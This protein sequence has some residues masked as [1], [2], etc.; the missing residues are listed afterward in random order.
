MKI[1]QALTWTADRFPERTGFAGERRMTYREWDE[2]T[3]KIANAML[4]LGVQ[5]GDRVATFTANTEVM[6]STHLA[7][8]KIGAMSTPLNI[9]LSVPELTYCINDAEPRLV[10]T[11]DHAREVAEKT[12]S[13]TSAGLVLHSG[14]A[15]VEG[16][17]DFDT[18]VSDAD[19]DAPGLPITDDD[20]SVMLYTSGTTGKPKGVPR[21]QRNEFAASTAHVM[22]C[23]YGSGES[24]LGAMPMYHTMGLR[25]L[26]SMVLV[27]GKFVEMP[28]FQP[29]KSIDLIE[30]EE[31]SALYLVPTA[32]WAMA[33]TGDLA[34]VAKSV[35]KL[36][37]AGAAMTSSL[38]EQL[39]ELIQPE[40]FVNHYGSSEVYTF[41]IESKAAA[42]P[43]SA[44]RAGLYSNLRVVDPAPGAGHDALPLGEVGEIAA[45]LQSDEAFAGYWQR[46]DADAKS[47]RDGWYH[48]G[49][50]GHLDADGDLW[51]DGRVDDMIITG[52]EN[53]HPIEV[54]DILA[55]N[56]EVAEVSVAGLKD[57]KWGQAVTAFV[58]PVDLEQ[59]PDALAE[60]VL[61]WAKTEAP[62]SPYK[63]PKRVVVVTA[64][65]KS[66][67]GKIL[68]RRLVSGE[69]ETPQHSTAPK[70]GPEN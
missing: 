1:G 26:L 10:I 2:R 42:K 8:Q 30:A 58:V 27:G 44:G 57:E 39:T 47:I 3:N 63:V 51:V 55:R 35:R 65:P 40:I 50:L 52:G 24:T 6:A 9:R 5:S 15:P 33:Q 45:S 53:V 22:Q 68:R 16:A 66:P 69:Y 21:T 11:D 7:L 62:L 29:V 37:F 19:P 38:C 28:A 18:L 31:I 70:S 60:R 49:D 34:R 32:Y 17:D 36:A 20:P 64:I 56:P 67:V 46:P 25:S 4:S 61:K 23:M 41:A 54:E 12:L 59:N 43:G 13:A 48:T 14:S